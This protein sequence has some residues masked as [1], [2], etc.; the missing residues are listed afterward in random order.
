MSA[1]EAPLAQLGDVEQFERHQQPLVLEPA[2][3]VDRLGSRTVATA[4]DAITLMV[5]RC[6]N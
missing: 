6:F 3:L 4:G 1:I 5:R 2:A